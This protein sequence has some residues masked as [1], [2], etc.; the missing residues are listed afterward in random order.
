MSE[1][2]EN[3]ITPEFPDI[4]DRFVLALALDGLS[5]AKKVVEELTTEAE[6]VAELAKVED[7][8]ESENFGIGTL[9]SDYA[10]LLNLVD[11]IE[12]VVEENKL[13]QQRLTFAKHLLAIASENHGDAN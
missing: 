3:N 11:F 12:D 13:A 1:A 5:G 9:I 2:L 7:D 6:I 8:L 10:K 4:S